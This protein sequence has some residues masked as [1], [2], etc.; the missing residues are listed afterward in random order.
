MLPIYMY[1][2]EQLQKTNEELYYQKNIRG[3]KLTMIMV[4]KITAHL[5]TKYQPE[6]NLNNVSKAVQHLNVITLL[7][8]ENSCA[9]YIKF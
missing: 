4:I 3:F 9:I 1:I 6:L 2:W 8:V 5:K 7:I